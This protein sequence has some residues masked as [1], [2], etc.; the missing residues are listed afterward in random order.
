MVH[1]YSSYQEDDYPIRYD[2]AQFAS[3]VPVHVAQVVGTDAR[4]DEVAVLLALVRLHLCRFTTKVG[5]AE[6]CGIGIDFGSPCLGHEKSL[7]RDLNG[8]VFDARFASG[9]YPATQ[10][11]FVTPQR[12]VFIFVRG[13]LEFLPSANHFGGN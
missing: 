12:A 8:A 7:T 3:R 9:L 13:S 2:A 6:L 5:L 10:S 1:R 11:A 4:G